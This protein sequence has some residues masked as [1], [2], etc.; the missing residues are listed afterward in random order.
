M[1]RKYNFNI[2]GIEYE[3]DLEAGRLLFEKDDVVLFWITSA[4]KTFFDTIEEI[5][6]EEAGNLVLETTGYRQ[7]L[8]V[9]DYFKKMNLNIEE[10]PKLIPPTYAAAG[11][12]V[13]SLNKLDL[14]NKTLE[15][16]LKDDWEYKINK[17]QKKKV[18][19][20]F[21]PAHFAG[22]LASLFEANIWYKIIHSQIEGY[23]YSKI[24]YFSSNI[25]VTD[26]IHQL[27]RR[28][29]AE[30]IDKLEDLVQEKTKEL[31]DL[32]KSISSPII[33]VLEGIVVVPLLGKY[34]D[35]RAEE[36]IDKVL[37]QIPNHQAKYLVL[38]LTGLDQDISTYTLSFIEKLVSA[39]SLIG[40][41]TIL[42][43]IGPE[44]SLKIS[45]LQMDLS[46]FDCF[47]T[48]QHGIYYALGQA[49]RR[50]I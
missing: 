9:G 27:T 20:S 25:T 7:G 38:D 3:W 26:N 32:V 6:G 8:V 40:T 12:G 31:K 24:K 42:V 15:V 35:E 39:A 34:D 10:L 36:L 1:D 43:G 46:G 14:E 49:G 13:V 2:E 33:P 22:V 16:E 50:I 47:Q 19:G 37:H 5:S 18:G 11:W 48:L 30:Q 23:E 44:L 41:K 4:M 29:E 45:Q 28:K 21:L 17:K